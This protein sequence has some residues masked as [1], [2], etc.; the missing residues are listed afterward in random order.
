MT[1]SAKGVVMLAA[2]LIGAAS[3][4]HAEDAPIIVTAAPLKATTGMGAYATL[5]LDTD[6]LRASPANRIEDVL[7][8]VAG[9]TEFRR[10]DSR[11]A[12]P[13]AQGITL[14]S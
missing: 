4:A 3:A 12:N 14:R 9:L 1:R 7:R 6:Q 2:W 8:D 11:A 13:S 5:T 10:S